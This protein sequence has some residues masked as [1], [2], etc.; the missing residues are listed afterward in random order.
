[1]DEFTELL[2]VVKNPIERSE[3][4]KHL[5]RVLEMD[6]RLVTSVVSKRFLEQ[7]RRDGM[8]PLRP[9]EDPF[10][11]QHTF[12]KRSELL[13]EELIA[14][15]YED[16]VIRQELL[17]RIREQDLQF[18]FEQ[19]PLYFFLVQAGGEGDPLSL[20]ADQTLKGE[21]TRLSFRLLASPEIMEKTGEERQAILADMAGR[22]LIDVHTEVTKREKL[23]S[24]EKSIA[25]ARAQEDKTLEKKLLAEFVAVSGGGQ[26]G[27][28]S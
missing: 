13:R 4:I 6:E 22:Y 1:V 7:S 19:H 8:A 28:S 26:A 16:R 24:L 11:D 10:R 27:L 21:V 12:G 9:P 25:E 17:K 15:M 5:A 3:A 23:L 2:M 14:L 20:I 18:F